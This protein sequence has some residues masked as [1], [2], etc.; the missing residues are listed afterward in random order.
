MYN[1]STLIF[2]CPKRGEHGCSETFAIG[3]T[4]RD[5]V[6]SHLS[7]KHFNG[8]TPFYCDKCQIRCAT[9]KELREFH[10]EDDECANIVCFF[11]KYSLS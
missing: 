8:Y 3:T 6:R 4:T 7:I 9:R 10:E 1:N 11:L 2:A 5:A